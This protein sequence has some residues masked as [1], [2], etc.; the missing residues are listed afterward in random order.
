MPLGAVVV[1]RSVV[2]G[3]PAAQL[4][5]ARDA[6]GT[7]CHSRTADLTEVTRQ[8]QILVAAAGRPGLIG[9]A[10]VSPGVID[11]GTSPG[12]GGGLAE[13]VDPAVARTAAA[14]TQVPGGVGPVT[15][16]RGPAAGCAARPARRS[17][18]PP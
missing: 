17:A 8:A 9:P 13:D 1:G 14:L 6:T 10:H 2:V 16:A 18:P 4:L 7:I 15:T 11:V 12:P 5:L 3:K